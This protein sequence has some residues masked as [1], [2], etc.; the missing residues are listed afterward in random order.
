MVVSTPLTGG[1]AM[2]K[3]VLVVD[4][5]E[6]VRS[7]VRLI[8]EDAGYEVETAMDGREG[9]KAIHLSRPDLV[10]LDL[11]MPVMDGWQVLAGVGRHHPPFVVLSASNEPERARKEGAVALVSK[12][13]QVRDLIATCR[14]VLGE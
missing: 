5:E 7:F 11:M 13:F 6:D 8:L 14:R 4:D 9:L 12:P 1:E 3:R 2:G 10:L